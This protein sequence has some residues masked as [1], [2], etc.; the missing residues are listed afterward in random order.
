MPHN[1]Y[2]GPI[3][4]IHLVNLKP[5]S[6]NAMYDGYRKSVEYLKQERQVDATVR[7]VRAGI[8]ALMNSYDEKKHVVW[9]NMI[10]HSPDHSLFNK[11]G[12]RKGCISKRCIDL[13]NTIKTITDA[14]FYNIP[15]IDDSQ[16]RHFEI[17]EILSK[18]EFF[19]VTYFIRLKDKEWHYSRKLED[20]ETQ[21]L[22]SP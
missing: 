8:E 18:D 13:D 16:A 15:T 9:V 3:I 7:K 2:M 10:V 20:L 19:H 12:K 22:Q 5:V 11:S 1:L 6:T 14:V 4:K 21:I 17:D